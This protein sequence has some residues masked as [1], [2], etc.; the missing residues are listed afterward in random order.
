MRENIEL[1]RRATPGGRVVSIDDGTWKPPLAAFRGALTSGPPL[2]A[3][4]RTK[5]GSVQASANRR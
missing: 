5:R 4:D 2:T 1:H 3:D